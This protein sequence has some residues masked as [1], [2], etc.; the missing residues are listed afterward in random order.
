VSVASIQEFCLNARR[1]HPAPGTQDFLLCRILRGLK[2]YVDVT[3]PCGRKKSRS[4]AVHDTATNKSQTTKKRSAPWGRETLCEGEGGSDTME[5]TMPATGYEEERGSK[6]SRKGRPAAASDDE[7]FVD[8]QQ[9]QQ[10]QQYAQYQHQQQQQQHGY[11]Q[12]VAPYPTE[13]PGYGPG[14]AA[15]G[16]YGY[17]P[18][19]GPPS[20]S[21][22]THPEFHYPAHY[23]YL[24]LAPMPPNPPGAPQ[25]SRPQFPH[26]SPDSVPP[27]G[28][29]RPEP[30][31]AAA[32]TG[33]GPSSSKKA[34]RGADGTCVGGRCRFGRLAFAAF[35]LDFLDHSES[36][37]A[38]HPIDR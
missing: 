19:P 26:I 11:Y 23:P 9:Q 31:A 24:P 18:Y 32:A 10:Q 15:H 7:S 37:S 29:R 12:P 36:S 2:P 14:Y 38:K 22:Q 17:P 30:A 25:Y 1:P 28:K 34:R 20:H 35:P 27:R 21:V 5:G 16:G 8:T 6:Q 3:I 13:Y 33:R 4:G